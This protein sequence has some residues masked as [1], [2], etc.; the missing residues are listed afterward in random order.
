MSI[1]RL[2]ERGFNF[3]V[4]ALD[5]QIGDEIWHNDTNGCGTGV[6]SMATI[7]SHTPHESVIHSAA[8][9]QQEAPIGHAG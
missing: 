2:V 5:R 1:N 6:A 4:L 7:R 8:R 3:P 9:R